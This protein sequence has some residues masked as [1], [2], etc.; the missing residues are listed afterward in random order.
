MHLLGAGALEQVAAGAGPDRAE[1]GVVV[2]VHGEHHD[3]AAPGRGRRG[4]GSP[5]CRRAAAS[6][7]PSRRRRARLSPTTCSASRPSAAVPTTSIPSSAP[8]SAVRPSRTIGWSSTTTTRIG[9][10]SSCSAPQWQPG[11]DDR[12][13][14]VRAGDLARPPSSAARSR[15]LTR[16][17]PAWRSAVDADAVVGD[18]DDQSASS[19][20]ASGTTQVAARAACRATLV[21]ASPA[22]RNAAT[23]TAAGSG[24]RASGAVDGRAA[25]RAG[26]PAAAAPRPGRGR[27]ARVA[28]GRARVGVRRRPR[29]ARAAL[30]SPICALR[31][32]AGRW[33]TSSRAA[34][35]WNTTPLSAGPSPS[36][37]SRRIRRRSSS[38]VGHQALAALLDLL[39]QPAGAGGGRRLP[40][41]VAEQLLVAA[42]EPAAH[43]RA[44]AA[45]GGRPARRGR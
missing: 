31:G 25:R 34:S 21:S 8:S 2:L 5:R 43:A 22:I 23:S 10:A 6:G 1:H 15:R 18:L 17:T 20:S 45:P 16:P 42:A 30:V 36:C 11:A 41:Q 33:S 27:R 39:G 37:R 13:A 4:T 28:A 32:V 12:A 14:A 35:S 40:D 3:L 26:R 29:P 7:C 19:D 44:P 24:R 38:R 9:S